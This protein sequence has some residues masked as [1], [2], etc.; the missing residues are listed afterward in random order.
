MCYFL[1]CMIIFFS[2]EINKWFNFCKNNCN[3]SLYMHISRIYPYTV[4]VYKDFVQ[5]MFER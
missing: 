4:N 2:H 5:D 3:V 1:Y